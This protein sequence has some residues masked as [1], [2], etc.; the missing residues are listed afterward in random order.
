[1]NRWLLWLVAS[2]ANSAVGFGYFL[3]FDGYA[4]A[5][6]FMGIAIATALTVFA[7]DTAAKRG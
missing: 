7:Y 5:A 2:T 1:M 3:L 6:F 4:R